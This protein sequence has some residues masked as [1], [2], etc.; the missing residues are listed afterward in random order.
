MGILSI[1]SADASSSSAK[2]ERQGK[3]EEGSRDTAA[4]VGFAAGRQQLS[5]GGTG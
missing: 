3:P 4:V 1:K 2:L 5:G